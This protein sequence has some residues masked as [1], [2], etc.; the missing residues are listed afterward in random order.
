MTLTV[1]MLAADA[2]WRTVPLGR[3]VD[4]D[5]AGLLRDA[6]LSTVT[7]LTRDAAR[8][9]PAS[10]IAATMDVTTTETETS[11]SYQR[12]PSSATS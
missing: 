8:A 9:R 4:V 12:L 3:L 5:A 6:R 11:T 7:A 10:R 2:S 1:P